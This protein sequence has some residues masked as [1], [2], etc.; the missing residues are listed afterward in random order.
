[1]SGIIRHNG[2]QIDGT[3]F[4]MSGQRLDQT[5]TGWKVLE[6]IV[7]GRGWG[8]GRPSAV[9][10]GAVCRLIPPPCLPRSSSPRSLSSLARLTH[11]RAVFSAT[12][13]AHKRSVVPS[14][15]YPQRSL[16]LCPPVVF[17]KCFSSFWSNTQLWLHFSGGDGRGWWDSRK[18]KISDFMTN[19]SFQLFRFD[20]VGVT[21]L[22]SHRPWLVCCIF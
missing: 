21:N 4:I 13:A 12:A 14:A 20:I 7:Y 8:R 1:M 2:V 17:V 15:Q 3:W 9:S 11:R 22:P 10:P 16:R 6:F 18:Y 19:W 5:W